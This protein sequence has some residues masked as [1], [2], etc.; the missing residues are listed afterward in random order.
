LCDSVSQRRGMQ[1]GPIGY[2]GWLTVVVVADELHNDEPLRENG[3]SRK[4][5]LPQFAV[6]GVF[7]KKVEKL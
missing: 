7:E 5:S 6:F 1:R 3:G 2:S 4:A